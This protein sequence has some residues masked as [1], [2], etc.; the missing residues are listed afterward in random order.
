MSLG[1]MLRMY[2]SVLLVLVG[3]TCV[4]FTPVISVLNNYQSEHI[5]FVCGW[6]TGLVLVGLGLFVAGL[7]DK[8]NQKP[9][10]KE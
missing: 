4:V 6:G 1:V 5:I 9:C 10:K 3:F 8:K 2:K 7:E